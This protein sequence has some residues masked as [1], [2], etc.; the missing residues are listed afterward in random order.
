MVTKDHLYLI[1]AAC[2]SGDVTTLQDITRAEASTKREVETAD[3]LTGWTSLGQAAV[4]GQI[5][6]VRHLLGAA[7]ANLFAENE[8][9]ITPLLAMASRPIDLDEGGDLKKKEDRDAATVCRLFVEKAKDMEKER[10]QQI[11]LMNLPIRQDI[12]VDEF[13]FL[14]RRLLD[15]R[16]H[17]LI[18][19]NSAAHYAA[20]RCKP[21]LISQIIRSGLDVNVRNTERATPLHLAS[22][23]G[24]ATVVEELIRLSANANALNYR[25]E[26]PL[27]LAC[28][29][30][31]EAVVSTLLH[32]G[33][34]DVSLSA[35]QSCMHCLHALALGLTRT[36]RS[37]YMGSNKLKDDALSVCLGGFNPKAKEFT[38]DAWGQPPVTYL[39]MPVFEPEGSSLFLFPDELLRRLGLAERIGET[40]LKVCPASMYAL[41][42]RVGYSAAELLR[43]RADYLLEE[44]QQAWGRSDL[45]LVVLSQEKRMQVRQEWR[46]VFN[47]I[48]TLTQLLTPEKLVKGPI[49]KQ[50]KEMEKDQKASLQ[51][52]KVKES[53]SKASLKMKPKVQ[54]LK[55]PPLE[56]STMKPGQIQTSKSPKIVPIALQKALPSSMVETKKLPLMKKVPGPKLP[57]PPKKPKL[58]T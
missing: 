53:L 13:P 56:V 11:H 27:M 8:W 48:D 20:I 39:S 2:A 49:P 46:E 6:V 14:R 16:S 50:S 28:Y 19:S 23:A 36:H 15:A 10:F 17:P 7:N 37:R 51:A 1:T 33:G 18:G 12:K 40:L 25:G 58:P 24:H 30:L 47:R 43:H 57:P 42:A 52:Q 5:E 41:R 32:R 54:A 45:R 55:Q 26:T 38:E 29:G 34:A 31:H 22:I 21:L 3:L 9:K 4:S 35:S 44:H